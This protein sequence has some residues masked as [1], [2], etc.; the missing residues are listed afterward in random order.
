MCIEETPPVA[1]KNFNEYLN[2]YGL[3]YEGL[4]PE[5]IK[6]MKDK[7][8]RQIDVGLTGQPESLA[9]YPTGLGILN[10]EKLKPG[11]R[12][13]VIDAGGT[14]LK[15]GYVR[16]GEDGVLHPDGKVVE[17]RFPKT[18][19][20]AAE[21]FDFIAEKLAEKLGNPSD[22]SGIG[23]IFSFAGDAEKTERGVDY[24]AH[25]KLTKDWEIT[26]LAKN[27]RVG[28]QLIKALENRLKLE[29]NFQ[30]NNGNSGRKLPIAV[31]NDTVANL[32]AEEGAVIGGVVGTGFNL[33][34]IINGLSYNI[35]AGD[36]YYPGFPHTILQSRFDH[37]TENY[38]RQETEK[39]ISGLAMGGQLKSWVTRAVADGILSQKYA[40]LIPLIDAPM[41]SMILNHQWPEISK[42]V[43][44]NGAILDIDYATQKNLKEVVL[45]L[46]L[47]STQMLA[48][49]LVATAEKTNQSVLEIPIEGSFFWKTPG[50]LRELSEQLKKL[51]HEKQFIFMGE[52]RRLGLFGA[53]KAALCV[54]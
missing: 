3:T 31:M 41:A 28:E 2:F 34:V 19:W 12:A 54:A 36:F 8:S 37:K 11:K 7:F 20:E 21:F 15:M 53:A 43:E 30:K 5:E 38:G 16:V 22:I 40:K 45:R 18:H 49:L 6:V 10:K 48:A 23:F 29:T 42:M 25:D 33:A 50:Y 51:A 44:A 17:E 26:G 39:N 52:H 13:L 9:M 32:Y 46:R 1:L 47:R 4:L 35:E 27:G 24:R 14:G